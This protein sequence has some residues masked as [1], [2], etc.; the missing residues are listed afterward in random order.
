MKLGRP[1]MRLARGVK[2]E[3]LLP[4]HAAPWC[5]RFKGDFLLL[6]YE[7]GIIE[8]TIENNVSHDSP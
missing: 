3:D 5:M 8:G 4:H 6:A 2:Y 7:Y 1:R